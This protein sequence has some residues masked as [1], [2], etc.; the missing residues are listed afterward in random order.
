MHCRAWKGGC[1]SLKE[2]EAGCIRNELEKRGTWCSERLLV[3][4][5][6]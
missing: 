5:E 3:G 4:K 2:G 6:R 1:G